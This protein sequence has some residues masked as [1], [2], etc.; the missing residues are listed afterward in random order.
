VQIIL[1]SGRSGVRRH[2]DEV[3]TFFLQGTFKKKLVLRC[4]VCQYPLELINFF[5]QPRLGQFKRRWQLLAFINRI[6]LVASFVH[7]P[8]RHSELASGMSVA[9][10]VDAYPTLSENAVRGALRE[11][12]HEKETV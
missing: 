8:T 11:L 2:P 4:F 12:A 1:S 6:K 7:Q 9:E 3:A 10:I 5:A